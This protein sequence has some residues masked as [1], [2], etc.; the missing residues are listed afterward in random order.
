[1]CID[2]VEI[3]F[4]IANGQILLILNIVIC[5]LHDTGEV[6]SFHVLIKYGMNWYARQLFKRF[7]GK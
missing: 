2:I 4:R 3:W 1:M 7:K 5:L 6:L